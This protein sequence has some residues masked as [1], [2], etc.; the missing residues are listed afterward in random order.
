M[1]GGK[2]T[3]LNELPAGLAERWTLV[4]LRGGSRDGTRFWSSRPP[5]RFR[6][7]PGD[8]EEYVRG[9][10]GEWWHPAPPAAQGGAV[11]DTGGNQLALAL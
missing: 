10:G 4:T 9:E 11:E 2:G 8:E 5:K 1:D 7:A 3:T 6:L